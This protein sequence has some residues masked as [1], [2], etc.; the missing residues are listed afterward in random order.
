MDAPEAVIALVRDWLRKADNDL[1]NAV[2]TLKLGGD[3]QQILFAF[4]PSS[5]SKNI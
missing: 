4:M 2:H 5:A 3:V 1:I